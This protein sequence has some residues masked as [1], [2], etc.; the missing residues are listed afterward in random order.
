[1]NGYKIE[2]NDILGSKR[3]NINTP[4]IV[5]T[6]IPDL[7]LI[8]VNYGE[9]E[10]N[11]DK[12][13]DGVLFYMDTERLQDDLMNNFEFID[14]FI[15]IG[16]VFLPNSK[17][18]T[19]NMIMANTR[20][21]ASTNNYEE[22]KKNIWIGV[23]RKNDKINTSVGTIYSVGKPAMMIPVFPSSFLKKVDSDFDLDKRTTAIYSNIYSDKSY[24]HWIL[25]KYKFNV[26]KS[27][28]K[29]I[30]SSGAISNM[31]I[32]TT[33]KD[34]YEDT[35]GKLSNRVN[36]KVY[37]TTQGAIVNDTNCI[38]SRDD[39]SKMTM[40]ECNAIDSISNMN[41]IDAMNQ[42]VP[43]VMPNDESVNNGEIEL[44][45]NP[46]NASNVSNLS[47]VSN[48]STLSS[49]YTD[50]SGSSYPN[51]NAV[52][53]GKK[54]IL[55]EKDEP[56]FTNRDI[57]GDAAATTRPYKI[58]GRRSD[59][60]D[61][62]I[63]GNPR[64]IE[65]PFKSD[66][67]VPEPIIGYSRKQIDNKCRGIEHFKKDDDDVDNSDTNMSYVNNIILYTIFI[68]IIILLIYRKK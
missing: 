64:E 27:Q 53:P 17:Q 42:M 6:G 16:Q 33:P 35:Y 29:M 31:F 46:S 3:I 66:C 51:E 7:Y 68:I 61:G 18:H 26:D 49:I 57:V 28:F 54:L 32:P 25:N 63:Y 43:N 52:S 37:F 58:T 23:I 45:E 4:I 40:N 44:N 9:N 21:I 14:R 67:V 55:K 10:L 2:I 34:I 41:E 38:P 47:N 60:N 65:A 24:G 30:D 22:I 59:Y 62:T 11:S 1:M 15:P 8:P 48:V 20:I 56:W 36:R 19:Y 12:I 13:D 39:L 50:S 5:L